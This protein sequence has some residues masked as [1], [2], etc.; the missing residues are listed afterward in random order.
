MQTAQQQA[1][2]IK[3]FTKLHE[4]GCFIMPNP[5][6]AGSAKALAQMGFQ[7]LASTSAGL[8]WSLGCSD[9]QAS[10]EQCLE[11]L[12][13]LAKATD[14]PINA[15]F[16]S[17][18]AANAEGV[19]INVQKAI[20]TGIAGISIEDSSGNSAAP[21]R[22]L[23]ESLE[24][25]AAARQAIDASA[26]KVLLTARA[27]HFFVGVPDFDDCLKRLQ[28]YA[29]AGA[30]CLYAPGIRSREQIIAVVEAVA[31]KPVNL[32]IG[33]DTDLSLTELQE[34]GVR[35]ISVGG[36]LARSAWNGFLQSARQIAE[37]GK[38]TLLNQG[39]NASELNQMF[40][41]NPSDN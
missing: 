3:K 4:N 13:Q 34:L 29:K 40:S 24:R 41:P 12:T 8:C 31:P 33:W 5:W 36:A 37:Q 25:L 39:A 17:G 16:E 7:A 9:G 35:R 26:S 11:H 27:E 20:A 30:D 6:D 28:A 14:L 2:K 32:L 15:D 1:D 21:L 22:S 19:Y 10:L 23:T 18:F 38:F